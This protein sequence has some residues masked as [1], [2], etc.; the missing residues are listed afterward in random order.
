M[1]HFLQLAPMQALTDIPFMNAYQKHFGGFTEMMAPYIMASSNSPIKTQKLQKHFSQLNKEITLVPQ[2]LSNDAEGFVHFAN[3][4][5]HLGYTKVNWN[6]GCP[7]PAVTNKLRGSGLLPYPEKI[8]SVLNK[9]CPILKPELSIKLRLGLHTNQ[10]ILPI[11]EV[12]NQYPIA[13]TIIH[14]RTAIQLYN[15]TADVAYFGSIYHKL[16][17]PVIYNGDLLY[18]SQVFELEQNYP[19]LKGYMIGRGAFINPFITNQINGIEWSEAEKLERYRNFYFDLHQQ[20]Q[21]RSSNS[22]GF[23]NHIK[24]LCVL[25]SKSFQNGEQHF[26]TLKSINQPDEFLN[27]A[28]M[29]FKTGKLI[30]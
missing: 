29:I 28:D 22:S 1:S 7:Y 18:A 16:K 3:A 21:N 4:L 24:E 26:N 10:E 14:P 12:L 25:F 20:C 8:D 23:L 15:G 5:F 30:F 19:G 17:M 6:L 27:A 11:I 2:L 9:M 13:E